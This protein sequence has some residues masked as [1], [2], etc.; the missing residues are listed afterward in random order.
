MRGDVADA[1]RRAACPQARGGALLGLAG[2]WTVL[3]ARGAVRPSAAHSPGY[4]AALGCALIWSTYS[5]LQRHFAAV[6]ADAVRGPCTATAPARDA[7]SGRPAP[8]EQPRP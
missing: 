2:V 1:P 4:L 5:V 6:S 3:A 8:R 7:G